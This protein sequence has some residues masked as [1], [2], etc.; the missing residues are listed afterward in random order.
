VTPPDDAQRTIGGLAGKAVGKVKEA[1]G[2]A[3]DS[4][5]L[6][7]EGRLQQAQARAGLEAEVRAER[8]RL[9]NQVATEQ[10]EAQ[11]EGDRAA[12]EHRADARAANERSAADAEQ[13][14][15][16]EQADRSVSAA[17]DSRVRAAQEANRLERE[18]HEAE[19]RADALDPTEED[20]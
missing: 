18:A 17:E 4:D 11:I 3:T 5:E 9:A 12:T 20:S 8:D 7:R 6:E 1:L 13:A 14:R 2:Q 10:R 15:E 16:R 19:R